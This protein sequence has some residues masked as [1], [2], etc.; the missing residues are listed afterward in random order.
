M[1]PVLPF[2]PHNPSP[3]IVT[4]HWDENVVVI[5][6][7]GVLDMLTAPDLER[8]IDD[9]LDKQP[10]AMIIDLSAVEF[11][12]AHGMTVLMHTHGRLDDAVFVVVADGPVTRR[13]MTLVGLTSMLTV[14][15]TLA[16]ALATLGESKSSITV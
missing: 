1:S 6:C 10:T 3:C 7:T 13:P 2:E 4:E 5:A 15:T 16:E 12:A 14:R 8:R 11:L 9:A